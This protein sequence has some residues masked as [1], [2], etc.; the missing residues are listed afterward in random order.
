MTGY[1][2]GS[3]ERVSALSSWNGVESAFGD[4]RYTTPS[5]QGGR[6]KLTVP[7]AMTGGT[8]VSAHLSY[9]VSGGAGAR[10]VRYYGTGTEVTDAGILERLQSGQ[11]EIDLYFSF[12][13]AGGS[14]GEGGHSAVC[15]WSD[16][17]A[18][19]EYLPFSG[20]S[21]TLTAGTVQADYVCGRACAAAGETVEFGLFFRQ[22][23]VASAV[24]E[25]GDGCGTVLARAELS[26]DGTAVLIPEALWEG[27][28]AQTRLRL[29]CGG[30]TGDW[31]PCGFTAVTHYE[32]PSVSCTWQDAEDAQDI[33]GVFVQGKSAPVCE[34][35][36][37]ADAGLNVT[38]RKLVLDGQTFFSGTDRFE[39]GIAAAAGTLS[40]TVTV[41]DSRGNEGSC[42]GT[43]RV[44]A[45]APPGLTELEMV[46]WA[47]C[48]DEHGETVYEPDD[49]SDTVWVTAEG[50]V[51]AVN[52]QNGWTLKAR[53]D[54]NGTQ[55]C[56]ELCRGTDGSQVHLERNR[57]VFTDILAETRDWEIRIELEDCFEK[58][59]Y[60]L[61]VPKA[62]GIFDLEKGGVAVGMRSTGTEAL[63]LFEVA[64]PAVFYE[65][66][67]FAG[68]DSGWKSPALSDC[69]E[70]SQDYPVRARVKMG[71]LYLRGAVKMSAALASGLTKRILT[72]PEGFAP[73]YPY[74]LWAGQGY[75]LS[76]EI[77]TDG[78]VTLRNRSGAALTTGLMVSVA[79]SLPLD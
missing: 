38:E 66:V 51:S 69:V 16:I 36:W 71:I 75:G 34:I 64:Y 52:G 11:K 60:D 47:A 57:L 1:L 2:T 65:G 61:T 74:T 56:V 12:R 41:K 79:C 6:V 35:Q 42:T 50:A 33:C 9:A 28:T 44:Y 59:I 20:V 39:T 27:R 29:T 45:Y 15:T 18:E 25:M 78:D 67:R 3:P 10:H 4:V 30:V 24:L 55:R 46:R 7:D 53:Y 49:G 48:A 19:V 14:G 8:F 32:P 21:G 17:E 63:P 72:L 5:V 26:G 70:Y 77:G 58:A 54:R 40:Y 62:G 76:V 13:A 73:R 37:T 43:I 68:E 23:E 22:S 31:T